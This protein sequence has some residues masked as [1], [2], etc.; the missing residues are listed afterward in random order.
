[1]ATS[2]TE[3][4]ATAIKSSS[5]TPQLLPPAPNASLD[6]VLGDITGS[7]SFQPVLIDHRSQEGTLSE[8]HSMIKR[9]REMD[10]SLSLTKSMMGRLYGSSGETAAAPFW[11]TLSLLKERSANIMSMSDILDI[12]T[13]MPEASQAS[14]IEE[15]YSISLPILTELPTANPE[16]WRVPALALEAV[17]LQAQ[18][19]AETFRPE[20]IDVLY[21]VLQL[22]GSS[23]P[24]LQNHAMTCLNIMTRA[25]GYSDTS[26][27]LIDNV[28]YLVNSVGM[29][30]NTFDI[31]PQAPQ[32]LLMMIRLCGASLI[33]YLDDLIGSI[34]S[35][36]D[37]FH[38][39][40]K[41]V[42]LLFAVLGAIIDESAKSPTILAITSDAQVDT[43]IDG[44]PRYKP[45]TISDIVVEFKRRRKR[46]AEHDSHE[47]DNSEVLEPHPKRP[48]KGILGREA[49]EEAGE[50]DESQTNQSP[51]QGDDEDKALSK[52]HNLLISILK[53]IPPHLSSP[54]PHLRRSLLTILSRAMAVLAPDENSFLPLV[55]DIWPSVSARITLA[56][57]LASN[58]STSLALTNPHPRAPSGLDEMNIQEQAYVIVAS[59]QTI[60]AMC[61]GAGDFMSS[62]VEH[63]F[64][65]W[66]QIYTKCWQRVKHDADLA[67]ERH[68][69]HQRRL[70]QARRREND[71][72]KTISQIE[73]LTITQTSSTNETT[74][75]ST[76]SSSST[77]SLPRGPPPLP[78]FASKS[79][80]P[81]H[82]IWS[83][84][85]SLF[86]TILV[87]VRLP[88]DV[89]DDI[90]Q[91]LG[92]WIPSFYPN[93]YF[94]YS[95][96][97]TQCSPADDAQTTR[98]T[99]PDSSSSEVDID[100][101]IRAMDAWNADLTW[102]I[103][104]R[105]RA[106]S[107][108]NRQEG[109]FDVMRT[110]L[111]GRLAKILNSSAEKEDVGRRR[112]AEMERWRRFEDKGEI[113]QFDPKQTYYFEP[114]KNIN[115][116]EWIRMTIKIKGMNRYPKAA[117][118]AMKCRE[119]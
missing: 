78:H 22:M 42:E 113:F 63:D 111:N 27:M 11:I 108:D 102:L 44:Q 62:R 50:A 23:N 10:S 77:P 67:F 5:K 1:M 85:T 55:N 61:R 3:S 100:A 93:Y 107:A 24:S 9:L 114:N 60:D 73:H 84:L 68:Q 51:P 38:G 58:T 87:H 106:K 13:L 95:W 101:T 89:G 81:H 31:S 59:C 103:F 97:D 35:I 28:D 74:T 46:R 83:A 4:V 79:F 16:E 41:L 47:A 66:K 104:A 90:C 65:K 39:Y 118:T 19:L 32:V 20:L 96:K 21:P 48:W 43:K 112:F 119:I 25:C 88:L 109:G 14:L 82:N 17:A 80:T 12:D 56:P 26:T 70:D 86:T 110:N 45:R 6:I 76:I 98:K 53:S 29:K 57:S 52:P 37:A 36:L 7:Q 115:F 49:G 18:Q 105:G 99:R 2:L 54:S 30:F 91:C 75:T 40:P 94:T 92:R 64:P 116:N 117:S 69:Q 34:F 33:P 71:P 15:L 72:N 8:L